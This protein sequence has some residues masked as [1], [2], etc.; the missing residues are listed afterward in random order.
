MAGRGAQIILTAD[1]LPGPSKEPSPHPKPIYRNPE[2][3]RGK[4]T[5]KGRQVRPK[6]STSNT[7]SSPSQAVSEMHY[8]FMPVSEQKH[9][10]NVESVL[11]A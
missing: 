2:K 11:T 5:K 4:R 1:L 6:S 10:R 3:A 7:S 9:I 8:S